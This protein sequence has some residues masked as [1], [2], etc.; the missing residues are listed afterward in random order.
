MAHGQDPKP[1][2]SEDGS[3]VTVDTSRARK[4]L[5]TSDRTVVAVLE[6]ILAEQRKIRTA[7]EI[8]IDEEIDDEE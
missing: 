5:A 7:L 3:P 1:I 2:E 6:E 4:A 8:M